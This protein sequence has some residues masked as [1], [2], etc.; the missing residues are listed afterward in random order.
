TALL[1][2][3]PPGCSA[4]TA[5][6][7]PSNRHRPD[8]AQ[9]PAVSPTT[10]TDKPTHSRKPHPRPPPAG[11]G[12][13]GHRQGQSPPSRTPGSATDGSPPQIT[14]AGA[15]NLARTLVPRSSVCTAAA[16][17]IAMSQWLSPTLGVS[18]VADPAR[19][20]VR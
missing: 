16:S 18:T 2:A 5:R 10:E 19:Y 11:S 1:I 9:L 13:N 17:A 15:V 12:H 20:R 3:L 7:R 4:A 8:R 6:S 14:P